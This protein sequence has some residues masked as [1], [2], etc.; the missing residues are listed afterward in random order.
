MSSKAAKSDRYVGWQSTP[1]HQASFGSTTKGGR[2]NQN[3]KLK[4]SSG[5]VQ[6]VK[7]EWYLL[8]A[9]Q[10]PVGRLASLAAT[11]LMGKHKATFTPGAGSGDGVVIINADKAFFTSNKDEKKIYYRHTG[12]IGHLKMQTAGEA[13]AKHPERVLYDAVQGMMPKNRLS[14]YQLTHLKIY[15]GVEHPHKAQSPKPIELKAS[16]VLKNFGGVK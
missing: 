3:F 12:Y 16:G 13:L 11:I 10:L 4:F 6:E 1:I 15:R 8:D 14:R 5:P 7:S 2:A 9:S